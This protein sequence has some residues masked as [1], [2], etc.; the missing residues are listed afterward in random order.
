[1]QPQPKIK[2]QQ[3]DPGEI[4]ELLKEKVKFEGMGKSNNG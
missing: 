2:I 1:M 3:I 4:K